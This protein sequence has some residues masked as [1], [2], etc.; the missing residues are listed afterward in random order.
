MVL[1]YKNADQNY[2]L[3]RPYFVYVNFVKAENCSKEIADS[4][5]SSTMEGNIT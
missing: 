1:R 3:M 4:F 5:R 2:T